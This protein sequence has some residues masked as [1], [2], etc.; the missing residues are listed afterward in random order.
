MVILYAVFYFVR[1]FV[2]GISR[3]N[4]F[5]ILPQRKQSKQMS[6]LICIYPFATCQHT[7]C[8]FK[9]QGFGM[10]ANDGSGVLGFTSVR[11]CNTIS[12]P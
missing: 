8:T 10:L 12:N 7:A 5:I 3:K 1:R 4:L 11:V 2:D 9:F 6:A